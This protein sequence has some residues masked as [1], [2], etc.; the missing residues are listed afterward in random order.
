VCGWGVAGVVDYTR[1]KGHPVRHI[2]DYGL[3]RVQQ[4]W[5]Y[6]KK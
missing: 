3:D 4:S 5:C 6:A 1:A 2:S